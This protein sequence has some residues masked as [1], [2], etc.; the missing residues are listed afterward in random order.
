[1]AGAWLFFSTGI[2]YSKTAF[3]KMAVAGSAYVVASFI[4]TVVGSLIGVV[5]HS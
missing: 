4:S 3:L 1:M 5:V 2:L